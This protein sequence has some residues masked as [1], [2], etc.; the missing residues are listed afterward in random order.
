MP[1]RSVL[2][3]RRSRLVVRDGVAL[4]SHQHPSSRNALGVALRRDYR[5][6]LD[7][8]DG[9]RDIAALVLTGSGGS[10]C[11]GADLKATEDSSTDDSRR[12]APM[13][14]RALVLDIHEW[15][16]RLRDLE[17]PVIAAVEGPAAGAGFSLALAADFVFAS[18]R[19]TFCM[20][21]G[22]I[23]LIPDLAALY[24][25]P[26]IVGLS[27]TKELVMTARSMSAEEAK[28]LGIVH[29]IHDADDLVEAACRFAERF[30]EA[31]RDATGIAKRLLNRSF[32]T[33]YREFAELEAEGQ[34]DAAAT[35]YFAEAI[36][37]FVTGRPRRF[38]WDRM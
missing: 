27:T 10:F 8:L 32:E 2:P 26:R 31:S 24:Q 7:W 21:F 16:G 17:M 3:L 20:S 37:A 12:P 25:L 1:E 38:D 9:R 29:A 34:A 22:K 23:G 30:R 15:F 4:L 13:D 36:A 19:A 6:M 28:Q 35:A 5:D 11:S 14:V 18:P 33:S